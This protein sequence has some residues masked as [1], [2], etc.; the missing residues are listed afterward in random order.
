MADDRYR[1]DVPSS[2]RSEL[3][4]MRSVR[5]SSPSS[6]DIEMHPDMSYDEFTPVMGKFGAPKCRWTSSLISLLAMCV[7]LVVLTTGLCFV[8]FFS[9]EALF[10]PPGITFSAIGILLLL[11]G[12]VFWTS[13]FLCNDCLTTVAI[14]LHEAPM[15]NA[16]KR[17]EERLRYSLIFVKAKIA[18]YLPT[19]ALFHPERY[20]LRAL[21][22]AVD[23]PSTRERHYT[24]HRACPLNYVIDRILEY[25]EK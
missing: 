19:G 11:I 20:Q 2:A 7:G 1:R 14:K 15:K 5:I 23:S 17:R 12:C 13:E 4:E 22:T 9:Q 21:E 25:S 24:E 16:L 3:I 8:M 6:V 18:E 10:L